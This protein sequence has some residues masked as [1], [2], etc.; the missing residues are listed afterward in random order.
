MEIICKVLLMRRI[1]LRG[2]S[3]PT[4]RLIKLVVELRKLDAGFLIFKGNY[5]AK[6]Y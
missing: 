4:G 6:F 1:V 3:L 5:Y 2:R